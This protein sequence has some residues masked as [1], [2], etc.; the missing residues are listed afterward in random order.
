MADPGNKQPPRTSAFAL[1][2]MGAFGLAFGAVVFPGSTP[3]E[4]WLVAIGLQIASFTALCGGIGGVL[5]RTLI[6][7]FVGFALVVAY[8]VNAIFFIGMC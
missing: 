2:T 4:W 6:G 8:W 1:L 7:L 3:R 5:G